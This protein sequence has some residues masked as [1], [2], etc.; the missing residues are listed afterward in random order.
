MPRAAAVSFSLAEIA[1]RL[2]GDVLEDGETRIYRVA[3]LPNRRGGD[4][5]FSQS[6]ICRGAGDDSCVGADPDAGSCRWLFWRA[7]CYR[8]PLRLLRPCDGC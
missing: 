5:S 7:H 4:I 2:G 6:K 8:Q 3:P 1:A